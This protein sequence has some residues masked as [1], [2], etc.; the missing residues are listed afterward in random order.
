MAS[1]PAS[2]TSPSPLLHRG[3]AVSWGSSQ[4][5]IH[6]T[7]V[8]KV[9]R[10]TQIKGHAVSASEESPQYEV[11]S[12]KTGAHAVHKPEALSKKTASSKD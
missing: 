6:G 3:D 1:A 8:K 4:G 5:T 9:T 2:K 10:K 11:K 7:V 12:A